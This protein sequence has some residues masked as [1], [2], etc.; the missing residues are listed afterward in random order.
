MPVVANTIEIIVL[1]IRAINMTIVLKAVIAPV[2]MK[3]KIAVPTAMAE[4]KAGVTV[5]DTAE[6]NMIIAAGQAVGI[7]SR[8]KTVKK[9]LA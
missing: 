8:I 6:A 7:L 3:I 5:T 9:R 4:R 1:L 2:V